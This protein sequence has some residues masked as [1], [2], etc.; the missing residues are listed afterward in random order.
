MKQQ[1]VPDLEC[2][3]RADTSLPWRALPARYPARSRRSAN[4]RNP[5][6]CDLQ[7]K[8]VRKTAGVQQALHKRAGL[9]IENYMSDALEKRLIKAL[10]SVEAH[11]D[12]APAH[13]HDPMTMLLRENAIQAHLMRWDDTRGR[14]VLTGTGR[15]RI[16]AGSRAPGTVVSLRRQG[17][18]GGG[19]PQRKTRER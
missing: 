14:Y 12:V 7:T 11:G 16:S 15:R 8:D 13:V 3:E 9:S 5:P 10:K 19:G 18:M 1:L 6:I 4:D 17:V 2:P